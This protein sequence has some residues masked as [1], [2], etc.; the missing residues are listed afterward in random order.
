M[1]TKKII[2]AHILRLY[3]WELLIQE[4]N[5]QKVAGKDPL[6]GATFSL[7]PIIPVE[8]EP[9]IADS[10]KPYAIYGYAENESR[11]LEQIK[12]GVF[13][14][15]VI[16]P[17]FSELT[18]IINTVALAFESSDISTEAVNRYSSKYTG[19][20]LLGLR[21]TYTKATYV[22]GGEAAETEGG[23]MDGVVNI[24]YRYINNLPN[25]FL[26]SAK[27]GLWT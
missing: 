1:I 7:V 27:G 26:N 18:H 17:T 3:I 25:P 6:T 22:E 24:T 8:D 13:S 14:L 16:A 10:D 5:M 11:N 19:E 20:A 4:I 9:K 23:P 12:E 2:P 21:F 15:R